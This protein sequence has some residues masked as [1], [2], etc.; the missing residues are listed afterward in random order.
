M[1]SSLQKPLPIEVSIA[2][3]LY[4][5]NGSIELLKVQESDTTK[6]Q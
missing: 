2:D 1:A 4:N 3:L 5:S 6:A